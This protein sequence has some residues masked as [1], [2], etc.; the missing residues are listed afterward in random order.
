MFMLIVAFLI[1]GNPAPIPPVYY[2]KA[3]WPT[4]AACEQFLASP[5]GQDSLAKLAEA[6]HSQ[7]SPDVTLKPYCSDKKP[8]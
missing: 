8:E 5:D 1:G 3:T 7:V 6:V 2:N 4:Q